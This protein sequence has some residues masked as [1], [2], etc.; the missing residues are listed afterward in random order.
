MLHNTS[1]VP[2]PRDGQYRPWFELWNT[3]ALPVDL[4]GWH[5]SHDPAHPVLATLPASTVLEAGE[6]R[7]VWCGAPEGTPPFSEGSKDRS[8]GF[9]PLENQTLVLS[10]PGGISTS[11]VELDPQPINRSQGLPDGG[12]DGILLLPRPSPGTANTPLEAVSVQRSPSRTGIRVAFRGSPFTRYSIQSASD[13]P[14]GPWNP[15]GSTTSNAEGNFSWQTDASGPS[16][17]FL[18]A[19]IP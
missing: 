8:V 10:T 7:V 1:A 4:S 6:R 17:T 18:R 14:N 19:T 13:G 12:S 9:V 11:A 2:D 5:L 3:G 15:V 16:Q